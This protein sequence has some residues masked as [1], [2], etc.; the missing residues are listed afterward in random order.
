[1]WV[2]RSFL[3]AVLFTFGGGANDSLTC[4]FFFTLVPHL[5]LVRF[6]K[7]EEGPFGIF[8]NFRILKRAPLLTHS[9]CGERCILSIKRR[10]APA[11]H[12]ASFDEQ[13]DGL[14]AHVT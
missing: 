5:I 6:I 9:L 4:A 1:M 8:G 13:G 11:A 2:G 7:A 12:R 3:T 10:N 14:A